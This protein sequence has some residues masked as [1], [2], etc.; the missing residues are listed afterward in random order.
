MREER[1]IR[2]YRPLPAEHVLLIVVFALFIVLVLI[3]FLIPLFSLTRQQSQTTSVRRDSSESDSPPVGTP[4]SACFKTATICSS[5]KRFL[6]TANLP[7][8][9]VRFCRK[10]T[11]KTC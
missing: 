6:L 4:T 10:L 2:F 3:L 5:E 7:S 11:L 8:H 1:K 9:Q